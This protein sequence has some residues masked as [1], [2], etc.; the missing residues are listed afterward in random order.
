M[1][2]FGLTVENAHQ[3]AILQ[4]SLWTFQIE[5]FTSSLLNA[6]LLCCAQA[7]KVEMQLA[8]LSLTE[9]PALEYVL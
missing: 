6:T 1:L 3:R 5:L 9:K 7:W 4:A 2:I 8:E